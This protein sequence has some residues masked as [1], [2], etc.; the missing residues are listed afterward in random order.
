MV[1]NDSLTWIIHE[2]L[3]RP[4]L[5]LPGLRHLRLC[6]QMLRCHDNLDPLRSETT[7]VVQ[8]DRIALPGSHIHA[9]VTPFMNNP[10]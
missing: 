5:R 4:R 7:P 3:L 1:T 8:N 10:G 9:L 2:D 6:P